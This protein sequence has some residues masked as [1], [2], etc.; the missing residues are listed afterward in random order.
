MSIADVWN[1]E[2]RVGRYVDEPPLEFAR[3]IM[4]S[5][6]THDTPYYMDLN[7]SHIATSALDRLG[8]INTDKLTE[9]DI[10]IIRDV[11][12]DLR[13]LGNSTNNSLIRKAVDKVLMILSGA[14]I[15]SLTT[16][17]VFAAL[18]ELR[19]VAGF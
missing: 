9:D 8:R 5:F 6:K 13:H 14:M 16:Q 3:E 2:Y 11:E 15:G 10:N 4:A 12:N 17:Y 19:Q 7:E 1:E 18:E